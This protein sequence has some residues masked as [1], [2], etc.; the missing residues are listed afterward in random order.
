MASSEGGGASFVSAPPLPLDLLHRIGRAVEHEPTSLPRRLAAFLLP[1]PPA[2]RAAAV[3][4]WVAAAALVTPHNISVIDI[5]GWAVKRCGPPETWGYGCDIVPQPNCKIPQP[6]QTCPEG[7][8]HDKQAY[9]N[10][11]DHNCYNMTNC[12]ACQVHPSSRPGP[13]GF[14]SGGDYFSIPVAEAVKQALA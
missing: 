2:K 11:T 10:S 3:A 13:T 14:M 7:Q 4:A 5:Y 6:G 9:C 12:D 8:C 1:A